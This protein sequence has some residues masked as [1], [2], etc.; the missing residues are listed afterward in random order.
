[1]GS[2]RWAFSTTSWQ[3]SYSEW[4]LAARCVQAEEKQRIGDFVFA[5]DAKAAMAGR[6]LLRKLITEVLGLPWNEIRLVRTKRGRPMLCRNPSTAILASR[7]AAPATPGHHGLD[8]NVS[9]QGGFAVLAAEER[10]VGV[11]VM[12]TELRGRGSLHDYFQT[13]SRQFTSLEWETIKGPAS[14]V[15]K[16]EMFYRHWCLKESYLKGLGVGLGWDLQRLEFRLPTRDLRVGA[17]TGDTT[18]LLDGTEQNNWEFQ[19]TML[20]E[21]HFVAVAIGPMTADTQEVPQQSVWKVASAAPR[22]STLS[23][24]DLVASAIPMFPEDPEFW[25]NFQEKLKAQ[26]TRDGE[27]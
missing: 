16:L 20:D 14:D 1:M 19:E 15:K 22:F 10:P 8:F 3:P 9:H 5:C 12:K 18:L 2:L 6:L 4:L 23:F 25:Q 11:D 27:R 7:L 26:S 17:I 24:R 13:M 21:T